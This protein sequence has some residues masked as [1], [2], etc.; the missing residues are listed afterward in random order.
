MSF[1][2]CESDYRYIGTFACENGVHRCVRACVCCAPSRRRP[3]EEA[4]GTDRLVRRSLGD[5]STS[6]MD[7]VL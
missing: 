6:N 4:L 5:V 7:E 3:G 1:L 2:V